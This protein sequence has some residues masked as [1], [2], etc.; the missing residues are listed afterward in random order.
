MNGYSINIKDKYK[1]NQLLTSPPTPLQKRGE[2]IVLI[3]ICISYK[4]LKFPKISI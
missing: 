4:T 2:V 1:L 3:Y